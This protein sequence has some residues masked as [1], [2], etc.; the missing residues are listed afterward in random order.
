VSSSSISL[1][2]SATK[3]LRVALPIPSLAL[4]FS[5]T[6]AFAVRASSSS[7]DL[8]VAAESCCL[9]CEINSLIRTASSRV[10]S[11]VERARLNKTKKGHIL[12]GCLLRLNVPY[13][14]KSKLDFTQTK[15]LF[16][17]LWAWTN[18][19][20]QQE[21]IKLFRFIL[22]CLRMYVYLS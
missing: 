6:V 11:R 3:A 21:K 22:F 15:P 7:S 18:W 4:S 14:G 8:T 13:W 19:L 1:S 2:I 9:V 20:N 5:S 16:F 10:C 12:Q 17:L